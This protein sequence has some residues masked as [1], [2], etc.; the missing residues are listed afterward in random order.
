[1]H[2]EGLGHDL[3]LLLQTRNKKIITSANKV[4]EPANWIEIGHHHAPNESH[5]EQVCVT[6]F[7]LLRGY[8]GGGGSGGVAKFPHHA[9]AICSPL[10]SR[11]K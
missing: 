8:K 6:L 9:K 7:Q 11:K 4:I 5:S 1:M 3:K 2:A 10:I